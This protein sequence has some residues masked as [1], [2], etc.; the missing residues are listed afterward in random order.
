MC[1]ALE[2]LLCWTADRF[3]HLPLKWKRA[4]CGR[5]LAG[6]P[7]LLAHASGLVL[8]TAPVFA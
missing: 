2:Q 7:E 8:S 5:T 3:K 1:R 6:E 4:W